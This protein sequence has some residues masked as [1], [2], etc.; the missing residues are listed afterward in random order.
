MCEQPERSVGHGDMK[1]RY[2]EMLDTHVLESTCSNDIE[3]WSGVFQ[4][5]FLDGSLASRPVVL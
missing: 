2:E 1:Q 5:I 3:L 4:R